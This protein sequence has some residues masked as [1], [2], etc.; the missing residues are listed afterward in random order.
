M[1]PE[2]SGSIYSIHHGSLLFLLDQKARE[3]ERE[4]KNKEITTDMVPRFVAAGQVRGLIWRVQ[5]FKH[6]VGQKAAKQKTEGVMKRQG[7]NVRLE[8]R[9]G[10]V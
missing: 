9:E 7:T 4:K 1:S 10:D 5:L 6:C 2:E 8:V 3:R